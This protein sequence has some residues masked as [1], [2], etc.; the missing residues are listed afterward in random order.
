MF[1]TGMTEFSTAK[2]TNALRKL[3]V[4]RVVDGPTILV[5]LSLLR[6]LSTVLRQ[7]SRKSACGDSMQLCG[8]PGQ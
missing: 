5:T 3:S 6:I 4:K 8:H 1:R 7:S 2:F